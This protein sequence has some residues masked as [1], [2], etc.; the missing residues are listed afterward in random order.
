LPLLDKVDVKDV[1]SNFD[2]TAFKEGL[3]ETFRPGINFTDN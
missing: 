2:N 3:Q 1:P